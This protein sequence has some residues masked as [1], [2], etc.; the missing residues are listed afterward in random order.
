VAISSRE[1]ALIVLVALV[2]AA[3]AGL[4]IY[5]RRMRRPLP[6]ASAGPA[7]SLLG[8]LPGDAPALA[9]VDLAALRRLRGSPLAAILGLTHADASADPDYAAFVRDTGFDYTRD[10]DRT[11]IAFWPAG[12][13]TPATAMGD[14]RLVAIADGRFDD[15]KIKAYALR[16]GT[17]IPRGTGPLYRV[18]GNPPLSFEF[19][20][21]TRIALA[22]GKDAERLLTL[23]GRPARDPVVER[24]IDRVAGAPIFAVARTDNLPSNFYA[25]FGKGT[26]L[27]R[28]ARSIQG[29]TL[30]GQPDGDRIAIALDGECD[31]M[32]DAL[33]VATLLEFSRMGA[34][35][36]I[37]DPQTRRRMTPEQM[38]F[39]EQV[40]QKLQVNHQDRWVRLTLDITP[41]MLGGGPRVHSTPAPRTTH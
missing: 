6:A 19:L 10:L 40:I 15:Q 18:P 29:L 20:S 21:T 28:L 31:S 11:A 4:G 13:G 32:K 34:S 9:F 39:L 16:T 8:Q 41:Q 38:A 23:S 37:G 24:R 22:S 5:V 30:A 35:V 33:E 7:P 3:A 25:S 17:V 12:P 27:E 14:E 26:Q 1:R 36:A 2:L